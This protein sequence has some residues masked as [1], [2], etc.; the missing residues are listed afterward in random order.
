VERVGGVAG[1]RLKFEAGLRARGLQVTY[2][3]VAPCD[4]ALILAG[5]SRLAELYQLRRRGVR[6]VQRLDG[7]N[8]IQRVR[9]SGLVY[10][11]RAEYGNLLLR[12]IRARLADRIVYQSQFVR[13]WWET[14][15][16]AVRAPATVI[17]NGVDLR[18]FSPEG[19]HDRPDDRLR[20]LLLEGNL[21]GP[22][23]VG[24]LHAAA[25]GL[26]LAERRRVELMVAGVADRATQQALYRFLSRQGHSVT[27]QDHQFCL[28]PIPLA[29]RFAGVISR[30]RIPYLAR[31]AHLLYSADV[32]SACP[33]AVIEALACGLPVVAFDSGALRELV[34]QEGGILVPYGGDPWQL[35]WPNI[36]ALARAADSL[37]DDLPRF[38]QG[39][40]ARAEAL[41]GLDRMVDAYLEVLLG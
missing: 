27:V 16:G 26:A 34:G 4:A 24:L 25:L 20:I 30:D 8:W 2:D 22:W 10:H 3:P 12:W 21:G 38:Q 39:A 32:N 29:I 33:N 14:W 36:P 35:D 6:L 7:I 37:L 23:S 19:P 18:A 15:Y 31:S 41:L 9:W 5:T 11:L 13:R 17:L 1:F 28:H 40:R